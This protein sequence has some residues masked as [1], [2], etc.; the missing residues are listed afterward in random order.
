MTYQELIT[1]LNEF[2]DRTDHDLGDAFFL[3]GADIT[4]HFDGSGSVNV[5]LHRTGKHALTALMLEV[6]KKY[7]F[8]NE[9]ELIEILSKPL[10]T[11]SQ[12][13]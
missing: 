6:E 4:I 12:D 1:K 5:T 2:V 3:Y 10:T 11:T 9:E 7:P 8:S 13:R